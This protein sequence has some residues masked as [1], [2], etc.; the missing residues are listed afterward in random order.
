MI[1][2]GNCFSWYILLTNQISLSGS[3]YFLRYW[4][5]CVFR[6]C[7]AM[8]FEI[9]RSFLIKAFPYMTKKAKKFKN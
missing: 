6:N 8:N 5:A 7:D 1:F 3:R 2:E 9:N 4:A